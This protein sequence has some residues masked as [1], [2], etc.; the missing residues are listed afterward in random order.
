MHIV[1]SACHL[2]VL[3]PFTGTGLLVLPLMEHDVHSPTP[4]PSLH[5]ADGMALLARLEKLGYRPSEGED[6]S[7][8]EHVDF[9]PDGREVV[10]LY[11]SEPIIT[12][13]SLAEETEALRNLRRQMPVG[14]AA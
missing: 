5:A 2:A 9:L 14:P 7:P 12:L 3:D 8:W 13:P 6:G 1:T 11:G 10:A 4:G